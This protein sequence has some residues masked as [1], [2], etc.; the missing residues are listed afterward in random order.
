MTAMEEHPSPP[1]RQ[2]RAPRFSHADRRHRGRALALMALYEA[3]IVGHAP[4]DVVARLGADERVPEETRAFAA[5][6][7]AGVEREQADLDQ[8]IARVAPQFPVEQ[9]APVDRNLLRIAL[10]EML[11]EPETPIAVAVSEAVDLAHVFGSDSSPRFVNGVL[12]ALG[13]EQQRENG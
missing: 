1:P 11:H 12:G 2:R 6:L 4:L 10:Y 8:R 7:V 9:L 13:R 3:D 5:R